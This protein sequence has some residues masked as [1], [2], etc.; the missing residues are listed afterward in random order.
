MELEFDLSN[1]SFTWLHCAGLGGLWMTLN[2]LEKEGKKG[3]K[4]DLDGL[5]WQ[6]TS[7]RV[8]LNWEGEDFE[9]LKKLLQESFQIKDGLICFRGLDSST[10]KIESQVII[11]RAM[12]G[13]FLQHNSTHKS[14]AVDSKSFS[15][16]GNQPE[17]VINYKS[18]TSYIHQDFASKLCDKN[19]KLQTKQ[20]QVAGWLQPGAVVRH[21][22]F[23][24]NTS[25][26]EPPE[27]ALILLF[28]PVACCY[29]I[30]KS[31]LREQ[32]SQ[33][34]LVIP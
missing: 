19:G 22:A 4:D 32:R 21:M 8:R 7:R 16:D 9:V 23:A 33:Y 24:A 13:T 2:Q 3:H 20:I 10:M 34:A 31:Q 17:L 14:K 5:D 6:L 27:L 15:L 30:L 26:Y 18:L 28:A 11:H 25:F 1:P 29:F 12:L